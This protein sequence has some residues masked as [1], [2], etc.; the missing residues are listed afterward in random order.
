M[1]RYLDHASA[2][3]VLVQEELRGSHRVENP[4]GKWIDP[5]PLGGPVSVRGQAHTRLRRPLDVDEVWPNPLPSTTRALWCAD[6]RGRLVSGVA[7]T[8]FRELWTLC[9]G[10]CLTSLHGSVG[11]ALVSGV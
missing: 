10:R 6:W 7:R 11:S 4:G 9:P 1:G 5:L 8:S 3:R 2:D